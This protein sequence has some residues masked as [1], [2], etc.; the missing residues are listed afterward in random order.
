MLKRE[1]VSSGTQATDILLCKVKTVEEANEIRRKIMKHKLK[2]T[3]YVFVR[4]K[5]YDIFVSNEWGGMPTDEHY[6][7]LRE[8]IHED[9]EDDP[10]WEEELAN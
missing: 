6:D 8:F 9:F 7:E 2:S 10:E 4:K 1:R 3:V 5:T